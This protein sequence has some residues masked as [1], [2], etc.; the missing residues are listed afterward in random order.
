VIR[1]KYGHDCDIWSAGILLYVLLCG[2]PPFCGDTEKDTM[3]LII[4]GEF[5]FD[6]EEWA[7]VSVPCKDLI[8]SMLCDSQQRITLPEI[9]RHPWVQQ[10]LAKERKTI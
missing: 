3:K 1:G 8:H 2:F 4:K 7:N 5:G 10:F 6:G 9:F